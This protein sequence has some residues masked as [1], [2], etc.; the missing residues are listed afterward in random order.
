MKEKMPRREFLKRLLAGSGAL[1]VATT[2]LSVFAQEATASTTTDLLSLKRQARELFYQ[3]K[4]GQAASLYK[5][6]I[7]QEPKVIANYDGLRRVLAAQNRNLEIAELYKQALQRNKKNPAYYDRM[8]R[9]MNSLSLGNRKDEKEFCAKYGETFLLESSIALYAQAITLNPAK[10]YLYNGMLDTNKCLGKLNKQLRKNNQPEL[11][12]AHETIEA[13]ETTTQAYINDWVETRSSR[14]VSIAPEQVPAALQKIAG[15]TRRKLYTAEEAEQ[16]KEHIAKQVKAI[17][18]RELKFY[19][20]SKK[21]NGMIAQKALLMVKDS[22]GETQTIAKLKKY[23][24]KR[25]DYE[26][27]AMLYNQLYEQRKDFWTAVSLANALCMYGWQQNNLTR[28]NQA[29]QLYEKSC[30]DP[31]K[32]RPKEM[33]AYYSGLMQCAFAQKNY[34][35][36]RKILTEAFDKINADKGTAL[37]LLLVYAQSFGYEKQW[38]Q[39]LKILDS[40]LHTGSDEQVDE[41]EKINN[42]I[43]K[44]KGKKLSLQEQVKVYIAIAKIQQQQGDRAGLNRTKANILQLD[45][46]NGFAAKLS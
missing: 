35:Q 40:L 9:A 32:L 5:Q 29:R 39:G 23:Y 12:F 15:K 8:A 11:S 3:K 28:V 13:I 44:R 2:P 25:K 10:K 14:K 1:F 21:D 16:R 6:I 7:E 31:S 4:Y 24:K 27:L 18:S 22:P 43:K 36:G 34:G 42:C 20:S 17:R 37:N 38:K 19:I 26:N 33:C 45:S 46:D 30:P 41:N